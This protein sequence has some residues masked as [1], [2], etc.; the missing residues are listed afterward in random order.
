M[1]VV[2]LHYCCF[3]CVD[4]HIHIISIAFIAEPV[5]CVKTIRAVY[6][7]F[8]KNDAWS[9]ACHKR[10]AVRRFVIQRYAAVIIRSGN[11]KPV[12]QRFSEPADRTCNRRSCVIHRN[13]IGLRSVPRIIHTIE[14]IRA[15]CRQLR[16][17][18]VFGIT[19]RAGLFNVDC[20]YT[21]S[22]VRR[23]CLD[24]VCYA[25]E[26]VRYRNISRI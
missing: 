12:F 3:G 14:R 19:R 17:A 20:F 8:G 5:H 21:A 11:G 10:S 15:V 7:R 6:R 9:C 23:R 1:A 26:S 25:F 16:S 4:T 18:R 22:A 2:R 13:R 24:I